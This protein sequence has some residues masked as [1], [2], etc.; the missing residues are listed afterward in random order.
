MFEQAT[1]TNGPA[2]VRAWTTFL[3]LSSQVA[4]VSLAVMVP[5]VFPQVLPMARIVETLA[6][7][8][9]PAPPPQP[10]GDVKHVPASGK[11][12][13]AVP[14]SLTQ[15]QPP[16]IPHQ[17]YTIVDEPTVTGV[18]GSWS[19]SSDIGTGVV[20]SILDGVRHSIGLAPPPPVAHPAPKPVDAA[21]VYQ[22]LTVGG[23]VHLGT[24]LHKAEPTYP[25]IA[26]ATRVSGIVELECVVGVDGRIQEVRV[27]SGNPL[28]IKAAVEAAWQWVYS[29]TKLN[30]N[31]IE[32]VTNLTF[33]FKLN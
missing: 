27:K 15:Y 13:K 4:I 33:T 25:T 31:P 10:L 28:L 1:L 6:P 26:R 9:P 22:R 21:P 11:V 14:W 3:G 18:Q 24:L 30:G 32:L 7:P 19:N 20:S 2:G 23:N 12:L 16:T 5:M 8:L 17:V 29:P